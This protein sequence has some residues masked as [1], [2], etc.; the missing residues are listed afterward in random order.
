MTNRLSRPLA[1][2]S[3]RLGALAAALCLA[4]TAGAQSAG[5]SPAARAAAR[6]EARSHLRMDPAALAILQ[7]QADTDPVRKKKEALGRQ[8]FNDTTLSEPQG[9]SCA[10]CHLEGR[11][12]SDKKATSSGANP[13]LFGSRNTPPLTY[14]MFTPPL[15]SGSDDG[16]G[17]YFGGQFRDG[18]ANFL[19]DQVPFPMLNPLEM[20][21][22]SGE[23]V[24]A[25]V[26]A[27]PYAELFKQIYGAKVFADPA[28]AFVDL[29]DA[30]ATFERGPEFRRFDS[31]FDAYRAGTA[32]LTDSEARGLAIFNDPDRAN[33]AACHLTGP[34]KV[35]GKRPLLTDFGFDNLGVPL[36]PTNKFYRMGSEFNPDGKKFIDIG[37]GNVVP[38]SYVKGQFKSPSLRNIAVSGPYMHNGYFKTLRGVLDFY[39]TRDVKPRCASQWTT[40]AEAEAQGCWPAPEEPEN[41]NMKDLGNL[42]LSEQDIDDMLAFLNT[43]TDGWQP[44][45]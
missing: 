35:I 19:Q 40:E 4:L 31:K 32:T 45:K 18:R 34:D 25:K 42:K 10:S 6:A 21:N 28:K 16:P 14:T 37:L 43:L 39:N 20:G 44:G 2:T 9:Q 38:M 23:A 5:D 15:Q 24:M 30:V 13:K 12:F 26:A 3:P 8:I 33:C 27:A 1:L 41:V 29:A 7:G 36:N 22:A 11:A 17:A